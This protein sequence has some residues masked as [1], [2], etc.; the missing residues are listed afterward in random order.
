MRRP[1]PRFIAGLVLGAA[2]A[3]GATAVAAP[4]ITM[5]SG[6]RGVAPGVSVVLACMNAAGTAGRGGATLYTTQVIVDP[7]SGP[8]IAMRVQCGL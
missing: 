5:V 1:F 8:Q 6:L 4:V 3:T 2:L 7:G